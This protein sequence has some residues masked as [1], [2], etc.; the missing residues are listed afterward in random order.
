MALE[1]PPVT[2]HVLA[3]FPYELSVEDTPVA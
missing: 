3:E 1:E 2:N